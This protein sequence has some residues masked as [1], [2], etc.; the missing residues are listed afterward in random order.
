M[1]VKWYYSHNYENL[2]KNIAK[3]WYH[4]GVV[5]VKQM[6][7][8]IAGQKLH[9]KEMLITDIGFGNKNN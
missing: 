2:V 4:K 5:V 9:R 6:G 3:C 1:Q 8:S 7:E